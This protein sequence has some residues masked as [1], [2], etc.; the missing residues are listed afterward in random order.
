MLKG[1]LSDFKVF[2]L[3]HLV[4]NLKLN[5]NSRIFAPGPIRSLEWKFK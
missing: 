4:V 3:L 5:L 1:D 2:T